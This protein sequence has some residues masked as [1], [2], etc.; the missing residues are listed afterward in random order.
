MRIRRLGGPGRYWVPLALALTSLSINS[1][2]PAPIP[3][4]A[5]ELEQA[6]SSL[7]LDPQRTCEQLREAFNVDFLPLVE[8]PD[9]L[10]LEFEEYWIETPDGMR[11]R[12][13]YVPSEGD[14]GTVIMCNGTVGEIP[15]YL[16]LTLLLVENDWSVVMYDYR[17]FGGSSGLP[18]LNTL[19]PDLETVLDWTLERVRHEQVTLYGQSLGCV[20]AVAVA[21]ERP[22]DVNAVV[23]DSPVSLG[24][25]INALQSLLP[26]VAAAVRTALDPR[27]FTDEIISQLTQPLLVFEHEAD[28][29]TPPAA[30]SRLFELAGGPKTRIRFPGLE[31][32]CGLF[33]GT[34]VYIY[35]LHTFLLEVFTGEP[36]PS[37]VPEII[38]E[39]LRA[40]GGG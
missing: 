23:L 3:K 22:E 1:C 32:Y 11:L 40:G 37:L 8:Y 24:I 28:T 17:G 15:C 39:F 5:E 29:V 4:T 31:H 7:I 38:Q 30:V 12:A 14:Q 36:P 19:I 34:D 35:Y 33:F 25:E 10:G 2:A 20:P 16:F 26:G 21:I 13:W 27:L 18:G 9:E 6:V